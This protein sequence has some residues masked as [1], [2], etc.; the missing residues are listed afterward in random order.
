MHINHLPRKLAVFLII[1]GITILG[2][3]IRSVTRPHY[4]SHGENGSMSIEEIVRIQKTQGDMLSKKGQD[5]LDTYFVIQKEYAKARNDKTTDDEIAKEIVQ[6]E[7]LCWYAKKQGIEPTDKDLEKYMDQ[8]IRDFKDSEEYDE[9]QRAAQKYDTT[10]EQIL[11]NNTDAYRV[12]QTVENVYQQFLARYDVTGKVT[13][14]DQAEREKKIQ[15]EWDK[16]VKK[17]VTQ[18]K[19][20]DNNEDFDRIK[21]IIRIEMKQAE[22]QQ[23]MKKDSLYPYYYVS[24]EMNALGLS[25]SDP[26]QSLIETEAILHYAETK[27]IFV[28]EE[29]VNQRIQEDL[30]ALKESNEYP[31][32]LRAAKEL[33]CDYEALMLQSTEKTRRALLIAR[34]YDQVVPQQ[35]GEMTQDEIDRSQENSEKVWSDF[36][37][38]ITREYRS[39]DRCKEL[40]K[41]LNKFKERYSKD[42][43][44]QST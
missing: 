37:E 26:A 42:S 20:S 4:S 1:V 33:H 17:I 6:T 12:S 32:Y 8:L 9:Y 15:A 25:S 36:K 35:A 41:E 16:Y 27:K 10:Y 19:K 18:Y 39:T 40:Q 23:K 11:R 3:V 22:L 38:R 21:E 31:L 14:E 34:V 7:A 5:P 13:E 24:E 28:S 30:R 43:L 29:E 2:I 44:K